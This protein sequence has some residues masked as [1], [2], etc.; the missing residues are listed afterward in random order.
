MK[1]AVKIMDAYR[2]LARRHPIRYIATFALLILMWTA[3]IMRF[4][5]E[6][7]DVSGDRSAR[8]L[9]GIVNAIVPE[10]GVTIENY[11]DVP[12]LHNSEKVVRKLAHMTEYG[13]LCC[14]IWLLLFGVRNFPRKYSYIVPVICVFC[15]GAADE[16]HQTTVEGRYGSLFDVCVDTTAAVIVV[17]AARYLTECYRRQKS[18][19]NNNPSV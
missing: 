6:N 16:I 10:A 4:S 13:I 12:A 14:L 17:L 15:L 2:R 3:L 8:L 9:V 19:E 7:A 11:E 1:I 18:R 5:G